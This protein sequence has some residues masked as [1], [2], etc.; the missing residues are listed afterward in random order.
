MSPGVTVFSSTNTIEG[1]GAAAA[2]IAPIV[3]AH[4]RSAGV[5]DGSQGLVSYETSWTG[6]APATSQSV[7][8]VCRSGQEG[9]CIGIVV[10]GFSSSLSGHAIRV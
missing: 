4:A 2:V 7:R 6:L 5:V 3:M 8:V 1:S 9:T 10:I